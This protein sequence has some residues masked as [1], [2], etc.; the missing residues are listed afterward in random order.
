VEIQSE[1][2]VAELLQN[3]PELISLFI[4][5]QM[6][7]VGCGMSKFETIGEAARMYH[8]DSAVFI[9]ELLTTVNK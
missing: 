8:L 4:D 2:S 7:C 1:T 5:H 6:A 9:Q 3:H